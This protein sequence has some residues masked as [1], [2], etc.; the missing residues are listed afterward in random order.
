MSRI[1]NIKNYKTRI[2]TEEKIKVN[3][4]KIRI[5]Q[6]KEKI[7]S[8]K[9]RIDE[10]LETGKACSESGIPLIGGC[11]EGYDAHQFFTNG[12]SHLVGFYGNNFKYVGKKGGG[13]CNYDLKTDGVEIIVSGDIEYVLKKFIDDFDKFETEFYNYVD[14][15][16][17]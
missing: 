14:K 17:G 7:R 15:I 12:W 8:L 9:P 5:E 6:Y 3:E 11:R 13:A 4:E 16:T 10:L 2:E 1:D